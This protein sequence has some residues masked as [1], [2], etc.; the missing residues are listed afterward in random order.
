MAHQVLEKLAQERER[1]VV[2]VRDLPEEALERSVDENWTI[3][4]TLT[5]LLSAEE[6]HCR[7]IAYAVRGDADRLPKH[8]ELNAHNAQRLEERGRLDGDQLLA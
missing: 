3:R 1:L 5:H 6:D 2:R 4:A 7:V 8:I